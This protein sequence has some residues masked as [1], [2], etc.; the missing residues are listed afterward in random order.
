MFVIYYSSDSSL[1]SSELFI[2]PSILKN[3][4][5]HRHRYVI[6]EFGENM[7][8]LVLKCLCVDF[9]SEMEIVVYIISTVCQ[10]V[11]YI[12]TLSFERPPIYIMYIYS[13]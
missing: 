1:F 10:K 12:I 8:I 5:I 9:L 2:L 6:L 3:F 7:L 11:V 4:E 13:I